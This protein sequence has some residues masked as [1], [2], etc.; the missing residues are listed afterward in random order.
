MADPFDRFQS[1]PPVSSGG[2][3]PFSRF[4]RQESGGQDGLQS[5]LQDEIFRELVVTRDLLVKSRVDPA[6]GD[7]NRLLDRVEELTGRVAS[8]FG[9]D[10]RDVGRL[11]QQYGNDLSTGQIGERA[12]EVGGNVLGAAA[13]VMEP[14]QVAGDTTRT[15]VSNLAEVQAERDA[16]RAG[17]EYTP[18]PIRG[19]AQGSPASN[20]IQAIVEMGTAGVRTVDQMGFLKPPLRQS[21]TGEGLFGMEGNPESAWFVYSPDLRWGRFEAGMSPY[22]A[23]LAPTGRDLVDRFQIAERFGVEDERGKEWLGLGMEVLMDPLLVGDWFSAGARISG[24]FA[25][26]TGSA[27]A[28]RTA[29]ALDNAAAQVWRAF[30]PQGAIEAAARAEPFGIMNAVGKATTYGFNSFLDAEIPGGLW[31]YSSRQRDA[32]KAMGFAD[33]PNPRIRDLFF[34]NG[35]VEGLGGQPFEFLTGGDNFGLSIGE[36]AMG[37]ERRIREIALR[38]AQEVSKSLTDGLPMRRGLRLPG[39][40]VAAPGA[41]YVVPELQGYVRGLGQI[42]GDFVDIQGPGR[43]GL[44]SNIKNR[45]ESLSLSYQIPYNETLQRFERATAAT[46][47]VTMRVGYEVSGY[48]DY[49]TAM[50]RAASDLGLEYVDVRRAYERQ[51]G[52][53]DLQQLEVE[54]FFP[55]VRASETGAIPVDDAARARARDLKDQGFYPDSEAWNMFEETVARHLDDM[56]R[57]DLR[58]VDPRTYLTGMREGY[59]RRNFLAVEDPQ[60]AMRALENKQ[61][62]TLRQAGQEPVIDGIRQAYGSDA[63]DAARGFFRART[64]E[65][66]RGMNPED[67]GAGAMVF[68]TDDLAS[69]LSRYSGQNV[70]VDDVAKII[71]GNDANFRYLQET[72]DVVRPY[73][74]RQRAGDGSGGVV[75]GMTPSAFQAREEFN[76]DEIVQRIVGQDPVQA[77]AQV[78]RRGGRQVRAQSFLG[79]SYDNLTDLGM[80]IDSSKAGIKPHQTMIQHFDGPGGARYVMLPNQPGVWGPLAGKGIPYDAARLMVNTIQSGGGA[81][82]TAGR[83]FSMMRRGLI[84]PLSTSLRNVIGNFILINQAGGNLPDMLQALPEAHALRRA[85]KET[86]ELTGDLR[87]YEH[88]FSWMDSST[89]TGMAERG[90]DDLLRNMARGDM[91]IEGRID[92]FLDRAE[93]VVE[94]QSTTPLAGGFLNW[95][96]YGEEVSRMTAFITK[97]RE[98]LGAGVDATEAVERAAHFAANAAYNYGA[99]PL[100]PDFLKRTGLSAF[101]QFTWFTMG[102]T[103]RVL[104]Q[105]PQALARVEYGREAVNEALLGGDESE[106]VAL[107]EMMATWL[108]ATQPLAFPIPNE[109]G[110]YYVADFSYLLPQ[111]ANAADLIQELF[112]G[113][114][115]SPLI[116]VAWATFEGTGRGPF[117]ARYGTQFFSPSA[118]IPT[119]VG[120]AAASLASQAVFPGL[121]RVGGQVAEAVDYGMN[122]DAMDLLSIMQSRYHNADLAQAVGRFVGINTRQ[123]STRAGGQS[124]QQRVRDVQR[125]NEARLADITRRMEEAIAKTAEG[126]TP[127]IRE[128]ARAELDRLVEMRNRI[129]DETAREISRLWGLTR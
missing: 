58:G 27:A 42:V 16:R 74:E 43:A 89:M 111:G 113:G 38:G 37:Q 47:G 12:R 65:V 29:N 33:S 23:G 8:K 87:G 97:R 34:Q 61:I 86:G 70:S 88:L 1:Q 77:V 119:Q 76:L 32:A 4:S 11:V 112:S 99:T 3:D 20:P 68:R 105:N 126:R 30:T 90:L 110:E 22:E 5:I 18:D 102:R 124:I 129:Y 15:F 69:A 48:Q 106:E 100:L 52:G 7:T 80:L 93:D 41:Q 10:P 39:S 82:G 84:S 67:A 21:E 19:T 101:P 9:M 49:V 104:M 36:R 28:R 25:R 121:W 56:G 2:S 83:I 95:F 78:G 24:G 57:T 107:T 40:R 13:G 51:L 54:G 118:S 94:W 115:M 17:E 116:D 72:M 44:P 46:R 123:V 108:Q 125:K 128:Q 114:L 85:F 63:A 71:Y 81:R 120:Q 55:G 91:P 79:E 66:P 122:R 31:L 45:L 127:E 60:A 59:L 117:S 14:I 35:R 103:P 62:I 109:D 53:I 98:L 96:K 75:W 73:I 92:R 6:V 50:Q 64:P 26:A